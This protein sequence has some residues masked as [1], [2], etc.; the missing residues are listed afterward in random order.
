MVHK[1]RVSPYVSMYAWMGLDETDLTDREDPAHGEVVALREKLGYRDVRRRP[2]RR[3]RALCASAARR[4]AAPSP[5]KAGPEAVANLI[6]ASS[7]R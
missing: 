7:A 3:G 1:A 5:S 4:N 6:L 2:V